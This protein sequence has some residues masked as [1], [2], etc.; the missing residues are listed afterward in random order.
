MVWNKG[1]RAIWRAVP[2]LLD[3]G[4]HRTEVEAVDYDP[5]LCCAA[6]EAAVEA[7]LVHLEQELVVVLLV[8]GHQ[9]AA[10]LL[11]EEEGIETHLAGAEDV[12]TYC[13]IA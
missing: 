6:E 4:I 12:E 2:F 11:A 7:G 1:R 13:L 10:G 3:V 5:V 9:I 8:D